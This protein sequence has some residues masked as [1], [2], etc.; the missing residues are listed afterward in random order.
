[1]ESERESLSIAG[2]ERIE[3]V[4][5]IVLLGLFFGI[6]WIVTSVEFFSFF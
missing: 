2:S 4:K 5:R 3:T 1:M 6:Q